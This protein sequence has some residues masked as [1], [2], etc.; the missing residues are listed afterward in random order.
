MDALGLQA[1][2]RN[3]PPHEI[4]ITEIGAAAKGASSLF[5]SARTVIDCG[6]AL[7]AKVLVEKGKRK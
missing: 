2:E 1:V 7:F 3:M 5:P 6:A 4:E